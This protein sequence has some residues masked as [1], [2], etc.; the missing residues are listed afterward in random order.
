MRKSKLE[1]YEDILEALVDKI[2]TTDQIADEIDVNCTILRQRLDFLIKNSLVE[3]QELGKTTLYTI[4]EGGMAVLRTL[5][6]QKHL[7]EIV[8]KIKATNEE[9]QV[10]K[11]T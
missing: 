8:K 10:L 9:L 11:S 7:G 5:N 1:S 2:L 4:T 6:F 3:E